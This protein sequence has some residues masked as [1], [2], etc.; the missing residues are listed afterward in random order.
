MEIEPLY[1]DEDDREISS[2]KTPGLTE[3]IGK[4]CL[5]IILAESLDNLRKV[6]LTNAYAWLNGITFASENLNHDYH[7]IQGILSRTARRRMLTL[8]EQSKSV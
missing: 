3:D 1:T 6:H 4:H 7:R 8:L 5:A 2:L